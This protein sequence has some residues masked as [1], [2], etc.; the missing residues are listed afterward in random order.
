MAKILS[1]EEIDNLLSNV[2]EGKDETTSVELEPKKKVTTYDFKRPNL[3]SKEQL[4]LLNN[5]HEAFVRSIAVFLSAQLRMIVEM[6]LIGI[7]QIMYSEFVMSISSPGAIYVGEID[8]PFSKVILE[9]SPQL[10]ALTVERL[11][12]GE[13]TYTP[14]SHMV[15][16]IELKIMRRIVDKIAEEIRNKWEAVKNFSCIFDRF[17]HN[18]EFV[19]IVPASEPV[20][21]AS[22]EV[23]VRGTSSMLNI[24]YPYVW[25]SNVISNP[26]VQQK[27][28][29]GNVERNQEHT[30]LVKFNVENTDIP[31]KAILGKSLLTVSECLDLKIGDVLKLDKRITDDID[32]LSGDK[33]LFSG[34]VGKKN[35]N[36][37]IKISDF[38][39]DL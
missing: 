34:A 13:G 18:A 9:M 35:D 8:E 26:E 3:I 1:Q 38:R 21:V 16:I 2:I 39:K 25:I 37:A 11:F 17:E 5:I 27:I 10:I 14:P 7:D 23:K 19:Q 12:G 28:M 24:C 6:E 30:D 29:F 20:I 15:S 33:Q 31:V 22:I 32:I 36:Y 4:R